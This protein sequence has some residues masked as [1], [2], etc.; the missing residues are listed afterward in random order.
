MRQHSESPRRRTGPCCRPIWLAGALGVAVLASCEQ[1][2]PPPQAQPR[3]PAST[4]EKPTTPIRFSDVTAASGIDW[5]VRNGQESG[6]LAILETL[7]AGC[8]IFDY[9]QD[10]K[11]DICLLGGGHYSAAPAAL[12]LPLALY[13]QT[14]P[15]AFTAVQQSARMSEATHYHHGALTAD[16]D[17]DGFPDLLVTGYGG[18]QLFHNAGDGTFTDVT[19]SCGLASDHLW[20]TAAAWGDLN[21][22]GVL[23]LFVGHYVN[24]SFENNPPCKSV[25][26]STR[27]VCGPTDF[28]GLPSSAF[29]SQND[30]TFRDASA[31]LGLNL[32][33]KTLGVVMADLNDDGPLEIYVANDAVPNQLYQ[34]Q[35]DGTYRDIALVSGVA[36]GETGESDGSMGVDVGDLDGD[37]RL[38]VWVANFEDQSFAMYRNL[39]ENQFLH[40]SRAMGI[41]AVGR[42]AVGFGTVIFD[43]DGNG[44]PDIFCAN[45]HVQIERPG[46]QLAQAPFLFVNAG[47][48]RFYN[49]AAEVGGYFR[50]PHLGRGAACGDLD[51]NGSLDLVITHTNAP[52]A[53]LRNETPIQNWVAIRLIGHDS[54]RDAVGAK[55]IVRCGTQQQVQ[56]VKGGGSYLSTSDLTLWFGLGTSSEVDSVEVHWPAGGHTRLEHIRITERVVIQES[57]T[58]SNQ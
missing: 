8:A 29:L 18:L 33:G 2:P 24:W 31:E 1:P 5:T 48:K 13:R 55:V 17:N 27:R 46:E 26:N 57:P 30:G 36:L 42:L 10:G 35:P 58:A 50:E 32:E 41:A 39:G 21:A 3:V 19:A 37:G 54:S 11:P 25:V 4:S 12:P 15:W 22:D 16:Y 49:M 40:T 20:S 43:A 34:R 51:G 28:Q 9:D 47:G 56:S 38:D 45:G 44:W 6:H 14:A 53:V 52:A 23:D 7:G